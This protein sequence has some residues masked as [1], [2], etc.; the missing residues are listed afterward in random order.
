MDTQGISHNQSDP[1]IVRSICLTV[2]RTD[3]SVRIFPVALR[4]QLSITHLVLAVT[5]QRIQIKGSVIQRQTARTFRQIRG[6][7]QADIELND[8]TI[9][10][11]N[12]E[13]PLD[14]QSTA[15][16]QALE[17]ADLFSRCP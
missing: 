12:K 6:Q 9:Q 17:N 11:V 1:G 13:W 15:P 8:A 14:D 5:Y 4:V 7:I 3:P 10:L 16:L 2:F